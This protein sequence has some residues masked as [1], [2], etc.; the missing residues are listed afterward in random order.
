MLF[1]CVRKKTDFRNWDCALKLN[2]SKFMKLFRAVFYLAHLLYDNNWTD[3]VLILDTKQLWRRYSTVMLTFEWGN[4]LLLNNSVEY[5][6]ASR[7][8]TQET[9]CGEQEEDYEN[10]EG[11]GYQGHPKAIQ[12]ATDIGTGLCINTGYRIYLVPHRTSLQ[13]RRKVI[14]SNLKRLIAIPPL[15]ITSHTHWSRGI[16]QQLWVLET[17]LHLI[18]PSKIIYTVLSQCSAHRMAQ[19]KNERREQ[20]ERVISMQKL[21]LCVW[22][23]QQL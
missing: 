4:M 18:L 3:G 12:P 16:L 9:V 13:E 15:I 5:K 14:V 1:G 7:G 19:E 17:Y 21:L 22:V 10:G 2:K 20:L 23:S 11:K 6:Q 8:G